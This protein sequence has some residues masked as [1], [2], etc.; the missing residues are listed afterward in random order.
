M[1]YLFALL[2]YLPLQVITYTL[3]PIIAIYYE[4]R[5]G[6][7]NNRTLWSLGPRLPLWLSWFDTPDN[8]L[9]GDNG[10][11]KDGSRYWNRLCWLYRNSLY[12]FKWTVLGFPID[13]SE[14]PKGV[15]QKRF[16]WKFLQFDFGWLIFPYIENP[17]CYKEQPKALFQFSIRIKK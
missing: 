16:E 2:L 7:S 9:N 1:R 8:S 10:W 11:N 15:W 13:S 12:G 6:W 4:Y 5:E 14:L 17:N 3:T